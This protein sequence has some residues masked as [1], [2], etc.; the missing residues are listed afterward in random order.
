LNS[1]SQQ[2]LRK[3]T[4]REHYFQYKIH[5][6]RLDKRLGGE[7]VAKS[8]SQIFDGHASRSSM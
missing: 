8:A 1:L 4:P 6:G 5:C 7:K 2:C 3:R